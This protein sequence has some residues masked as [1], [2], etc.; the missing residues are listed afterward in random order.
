MRC[1]FCGSDDTQVK[2][3]RPSEDKRVIRRRRECTECGRRFTTFER[4]QVQQTVVLKRDGSRELFD[5]EKVMKSIMLAMRKR[6]VNQNVINR[7]VADVEQALTETGRTEITSNE[8]GA[9]VLEKLK[10][11]DFVGYVRYASV[12]N[13]FSSPMDFQQLLGKMK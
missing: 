2:D 12:Y 9:A 1:P 3:S 7:V 11:V 5:R 13:E 4:F 10:D 8:I 6:P